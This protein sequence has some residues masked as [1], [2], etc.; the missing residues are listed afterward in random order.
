MLLLLCVYLMQAWFS[1]GP[2]AQKYH[3][4]VRD[5]YSE[6]SVTGEYPHLDYIPLRVIKSHPS[7]HKKE[8]TVQFLKN[9]QRATV[10]NH[11]CMRYTQ[12][13][14]NNYTW[15][16]FIKESLAHMARQQSTETTQ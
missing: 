9:F 10:E 6:M 16:C 7:Q 3:E 15:A 8:D 14:S 1:T 2:L 13:S 12:S 11:A 5:Y 4:R